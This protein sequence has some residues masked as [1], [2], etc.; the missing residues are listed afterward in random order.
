MSI[1]ERAH[2][3]LLREVERQGTRFVVRHLDRRETGLGRAVG[4]TGASA[5]A[6]VTGKNAEAYNFGTGGCRR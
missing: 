1:L 4:I 3:D 6:M 2:L 5:G